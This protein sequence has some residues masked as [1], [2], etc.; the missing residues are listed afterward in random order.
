MSFRTFRSIQATAVVLGIAA[1]A[2]AVDACSTDDGATPTPD[3]G[4]DVVVEA[5][6]D[7]ADA[8]PCTPWV[9]PASCNTDGGMPDDLA[10]TGLYDDIAQKKLACDVQEFSPGFVLWSDGA[11]KRRFL[12]LPPGSKI[13]VTDM[14]EWIFPLGTKLW[15]EFTIPVDGGTAL[16]ETRFFWK[17]PDKDIPDGVWKWTTFVWSPDGKTATKNDVGVSNVLGTSYQIPDHAQCAQCHQGRQD[18]VLGLEALLSAAPEAKG[19]TYASL[20]AAG[21]LKTSAQG[22]PPPASALQIPGNAT[23]RNALGYLHVNCGVA[24]HNPTSPSPGN[25]SG[26]HMKL[27]ANALATVVGTDTVVKGVNKKPGNNWSGQPAAPIGGWYDI[28]PGDVSRSLIPARMNAR[29][30]LDGGTAQMPPVIT[31]RVD[32]AGVAAVNAWITSMSVDAGYPAP[33]P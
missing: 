18:S 6:A 29:D 7:A 33:A 1:C 13:D 32:D 8:A 4:T 16:V 28:R 5:S 12:Y 31:H 9:A 20:L 24:C 10:C 19:V 23:E 21:R 22:G 15:K 17:A 25:L 27:K 11:A 14:D 2:F 26:L 30:V 3:A